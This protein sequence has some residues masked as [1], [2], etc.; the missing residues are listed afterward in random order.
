[1]SPLLGHSA[2]KA[3]FPCSCFVGLKLSGIIDP[4]TEPEVEPRIFAPRRGCTEGRTA[5]HAAHPSPAVD[6]HPA[7]F[8]DRI[9]PRHLLLGSYARPSLA[10]VLAL[11]RAGGGLCLFTRTLFKT[12]CPIIILSAFRRALLLRFPMLPLPFTTHIMTTVEDMHPYDDES[13]KHSHAVDMTAPRRTTDD[14]QPA[15]TEAPPPRPPKPNQYAHGS[16]R[17]AAASGLRGDPADIEMTGMSAAPITTG[18]GPR[19]TGSG[20]Q[21]SAQSQSLDLLTAVSDEEEWSKRFP[22]LSSLKGSSTTPGEQQ[23]SMPQQEKKGQDKKHEAYQYPLE[24]RFP[25]SPTPRAHSSHLQATYSQSNR[26]PTYPSVP[27]PSHVPVQT[28]VKSLPPLPSEGDER[29]RIRATRTSPSKTSTPP[30]TDRARE[31]RKLQRKTRPDSARPEQPG[32]PIEVEEDEGR[33]KSEKRED[34]DDDDV[35]SADDDEQF[36]DTHPH[37]P[38]KVDLHTT[39]EVGKETCTKAEMDALERVFAIELQKMSEQLKEANSRA[40]QAERAAEE[41]RL[42]QRAEAKKARELTKQD[43]ANSGDET[44]V[45]RAEVQSLR[46]ELDEARSHIFSLQPYLKDL[47]PNEANQVRSQ[48]WSTLQIKDWTV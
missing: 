30:N 41:L 9:T 7:P 27:P 32:S 15:S 3:A 38:N 35:M 26:V 2:D 13:I 42:Q 29:E 33:I 19:T 44:A 45:L 6:N 37:P 20:L 24:Q 10:P 46:A 23:Q 21:R 43:A 17:D 1:V 25:Y 40:E 31:R 4:L 16:Y 36:M 11:T 22:P 47:T 14:R 12:F 28:D 39:Q 34:D 5:E 8:H 48:W 18:T